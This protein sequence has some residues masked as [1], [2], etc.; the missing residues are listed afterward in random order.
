MAHAISLAR[1]A[2]APGILWAALQGSGRLACLGLL[3]AGATDILDGYVSRRT[4]SQS[5]FGRRLD[6]TADSM[7]LIA[8]GAALVILNPAILKDSWPLLTATAILDPLSA[9]APRRKPTKS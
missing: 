2:L 3:V 5:R 6:S 1:F 9:G 7:V 8:T 4:K